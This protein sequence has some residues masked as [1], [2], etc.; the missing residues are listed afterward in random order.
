MSH[1]ICGKSSLDFKTCALDSA[2]KEP[3]YLAC[4]IHNSRFFTNMKTQTD[5]VRM[6]FKTIL[7]ARHYVISSSTTELASVGLI[8]FLRPWSFEVVDVKVGRCGQKRSMGQ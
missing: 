6:A 2:T 3:L 8:F 1:S 4:K 7:K 5:V